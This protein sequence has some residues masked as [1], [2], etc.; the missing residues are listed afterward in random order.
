[1]VPLLCLYPYLLGRHVLATRS[2]PLGSLLVNLHFLHPFKPHCTTQP[3]TIELSRARS[4]CRHP[5]QPCLYCHGFI[6]LGLF[7]SFFSF[8]FSYSNRVARH[9]L[10]PQTPDN[11][12]ENFHARSLTLPSPHQRDRRARTA[13]VERRSRRRAQQVGV[14]RHR[15]GLRSDVVCHRTVC[16]HLQTARVPL[17]TSFGKY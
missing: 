6:T 2:V 8:F 16:I 17:N 9:H 3:M 15:V 4:H 5:H 14:R 12:C 10:Y 1:M 13:W 11:R 7:S